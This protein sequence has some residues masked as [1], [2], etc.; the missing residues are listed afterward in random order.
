MGLFAIPWIVAH[1]APLP[2]GFSR[3]EY[4]RISFSRRS[5]GL[6]DRTQVS[7]IAGRFFT[8]WTSREAP[9]TSICCAFCEL[10]FYSKSLSLRQSKIHLTS[11]SKRF[12]NKRGRTTIFLLVNHSVGK[13]SACSAGD[14][15]LIPGLERSPGEG[16]G[17]PLK[18][19]QRS[20]VGCRPWGRKELG[21]TERLTLTYLII[22][23]FYDASEQTQFIFLVFLI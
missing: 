1:Q 6:R 3:Q 19:G 21:M 22:L 9:C 17:N 4:W 15:G 18:H 14:L 12:H 2:T 20:L 23:Q 7:C 5:S 13:E 10:N 11:F 16:N 8:V